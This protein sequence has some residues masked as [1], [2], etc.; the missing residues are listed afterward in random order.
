MVVIFHV[1]KPTYFCNNLRNF[2]INLRNMKKR[3]PISDIMTKEV[4]TVD[5]SEHLKTV[6]DKFKKHHVRHL[7][8]LDKG[9]L[10]GIL[11]H[12]D[13]SR[14]SF[15]SVFG[16][17]QASTDIAIFDMLNISQVMTHKPQT[18]TASMT[19]QEV[20]EI[21]A[22]EEFHALPVLKD[23]KLAG[24]ITTTDIIRFLLQKY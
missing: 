22:T 15:G 20:A 17:T 7:P 11:S 23:N 10:V 19:I 24:I 3:Q 2:Q 1:Q 4:I 9:K 14:L 13:I 6:Q 21:F 16:D 5:V 8:V 12:T 18:V